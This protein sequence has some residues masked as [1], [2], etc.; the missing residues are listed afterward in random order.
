MRRAPRSH[1]CLLAPAL[2]LLAGLGCAAAP[3]PLPEV[4]LSRPGW[5]VWSGQALWRPG[6]GRPALAGELIAARR[7]DGEVLVS[8]SKPP[9]PLFTAQAA[10]GRWRIDF[11]AKGRAYGGRGRPPRRFVW[12]RLPEILAGAPAPPRWEVGRPADDEWTLVHR[13]RGERI[14]LVLDPPSGADG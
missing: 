12:F 8:F 14:R 9:L 5:T 3:A 10:G 13:G 2:L 6:A 7:D 11:V 4:D 1:A